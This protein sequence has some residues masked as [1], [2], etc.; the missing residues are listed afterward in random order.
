MGLASIRHG[1]IA[2]TQRERL[3]RFARVDIADEHLKKLPGHAVQRDLAARVCACGPRGL[4]TAGVDDHK[5]PPLGEWMHS[6]H[7]EQAPQQRFHPRTT[8]TSALRHCLVCHGLIQ[9]RKDA[10]HLASGVG[11]A[12]R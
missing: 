2:G 1:D 8:G 6:G 10:R 12:T 7:G 3:A 9:G 4:Q 5:A 11:Q